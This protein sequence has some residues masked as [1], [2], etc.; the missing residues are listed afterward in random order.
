MAINI[1]PPLPI[2]QAELDAES[3]RQIALRYAERARRGQR[4][5]AAIRALDATTDAL[6]AGQ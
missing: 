5:R 2:T 4:M 3:R 6:R 1:S